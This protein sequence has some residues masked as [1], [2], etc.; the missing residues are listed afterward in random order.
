MKVSVICITARQKPGLG[1]L[2][3][4]LLEQHFPKEHFELVYG[5]RLWEDREEAVLE[6]L[7][8]SGL[9]YKYV[10]DIP[11]QPGPCPAGARNACVDVAE[12][13]WIL[14]I[15]DLTFLEPDTIQRHYALYREGFDAVAGSYLESVAD[16][17]KEGVQTERPA[18]VIDWRNTDGRVTNEGGIVSP[19]D[20]TI[21]MAWWGLHTAFSKKAWKEINGYDEVFDGVY[22]MEDIDFGH[23]LKMSGCAMAWE[24][25]L[26]VKC[27]KGSSH[28]DTHAQLI[29]GDAPTSWARGS[30]KW[31]N[32]KLIDYCRAM[33]I[34]R[35]TRYE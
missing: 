17:D 16:W 8:E 18:L 31:R 4:S 34:V 29:P 1:R 21:W 7:E 26:L 14:S 6:M 24:P 30:L 27:D 32:D 23:R 3:D 2:L 19:D 33:N 28:N 15:D 11:N 25:T 10:R 22:G 13:D 5:D 12:G 20:H 35:G 9:N